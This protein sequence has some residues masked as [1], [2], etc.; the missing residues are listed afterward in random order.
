M[1]KIT[2]NL[3]IWGGA[4]LLPLLTRTFTLFLLFCLLLCSK[5][6]A[7]FLLL[8]DME[9]HG[10]CSGRWTFYAGNTTTGKVEFNIPNPAVTGLNTS[11]HVARFT[12]DTTSFEWMSASCSLPDSFDLSTNSVFKM[13]VRSNVIEDVMFKLQPGTNYSKAVFLTYRIKNINTWEEAVFDFKSVK[14]RTDFNTIVVQFIDGRK[15]NGILHFDL[16]QS[17]DRVNITL[18][19]TR[20][21][22]GQEQGAVIQATIHKNTF[23]S[24]LN[25]SNWTA[26]LPS[27]VTI[28]SLQ[29][30]N[31]T[32]V[33][34]VLAGNSLA[35]YSRFTLRL[36]IAGSELAGPAAAQYLALG[37][38]V[39][40]GNPNYTL[41]F[42][43][44]FNGTGL[45]DLTKWTVD[46]RPKG[47]IN[48]EQQ[49]YTDTSYDN[50]RVRNGSLVIT[51]KKDYPNYNTTEPWSSARLITRNKVDFR[52][53]KVE[54]RARLPRARG[55]WPAIWL[56]PTTESYG[57]WPKSGEIDIMEHVG[58]NF[59]TVLSTVH[60]Q[61]NNWTNGGH[62]SASKLIPDVDTVF[63]VYALEWSEDS[64]RFTYD[65]VKVY[66]YV[67]PKTDWKDWPFDQKF[68]IILNVAIG[69]GMGGAI[70]EANWPDSMLVDYVRVYQKGLGTPV[71]DSIVVSPANRAIVAGRKYQYT[72]KIFDQNDFPMSL[73]PVWSI[74]GSGNTITAGG[75]ACI[76]SPGIVTATVSYNG[77]TLS[78]T[79]NVTT[80][81][82]NFKPVPARIE[83]E[84]FDYSNTTRTE[85]VLDT[86]G[87]LNVSFIGATSFMEYDIEAPW[88]GS[89]RLQ[90][91]VA[92]NT[93]STVKVMMGDTLLTTMTLPASG[94]WQNWVTVTSAP[95]QMP[96]GKKTLLIQAATS[97][98]NFNWLKVVRA[99]D[100][101][102]S[103]I[104]VS[105]DSTSVFVGGKK[106][107]KAAAYGSDSSRFDIPFTWSVPAAGGV[108][109]YKGVFTASYTP[110]GYLV[111]ASYNS[112]SGYGKVKVLAAPQLA[113]IKV[114]PDSLTVPFGASQQYTTKGFDQ[115]GSA[116]AFT[117]PAWSV[118]GTGNSVTQAG[119]LTAGMEPGTFTITAVKDS[120]SGSAIF[121]TGY[122]CTFNKRYEA[123]ISTSRSPQPTLE[124]TTD[125]SGGQNF[126][127][128]GY[129]HWFGYSVLAIP[130]RGKYNVSF[131][132]LT[133][134][135]AKVK[136][137][138]SGITYGIISL[139]NTN[140][141]WATI[142]DTMTLPAISYANVIV[143]QGTFK[144][145]WFAINNCAVAPAPDTTASSL[146]MK[147][148]ISGDS[149]AP[150]AFRVYPNPVRDMITIE[151][152]RHH[153][154]TMKLL[155]MNGRLLRQWNVPAGNARFSKS[156]GNLP[157]GNY[158]LHLEG[159]SAPASIKIVKL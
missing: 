17:P 108:M 109:D 63:H 96:G 22:M 14:N 49:V 64:L 16:V 115:Y 112:M 52:Y 55:S 13:L 19:D 35:N 59:G 43:D 79:A 157:G 130:V 38:V 148:A 129:N 54:V 126:T 57:A 25:K 73:T 47:W 10:P 134:A 40:E 26:Q 156:L 3:P 56:M 50:A 20:I 147:S 124:P 121:T 116:F 8:D 7:Q 110:G 132:V 144:F 145:N 88:T 103:R 44:H 125:T 113:S 33:N 119:A 92:V 21:V 70:T 137:A 120:I 140:G 117:G 80:R 146:T 51:G 94:G 37:N 135:P 87:V 83:A 66:T 86:S 41:I 90:L 6:Q 91:R 53:G 136:L 29:R 114:V 74:T 101:S 75:L 23:D 153:Y 141:Q 65:G 11:S 1:K 106:P 71:P 32:T 123:E 45:P 24:V 99:T 155:D 77:D 82:A 142:T 105:P 143:Y 9:G 89:Y 150:L 127:G 28:D 97:G 48:G 12:K 122:G 72:A 118:S 102:L 42:E 2:I 131:R 149:E 67:N 27:G 31:D 30:V 69:G 60:T 95:F 62:L 104:V 138:N 46:P 81:V 151:Q 76:H 39:F 5:G 158:M 36:T 107:F 58:N 159:T 98:W 78:A 111:K 93:A 4:T 128:L 15:A 85:P 34:V 84:A 18:A 154:H 100:V 68:H 61:N 152:G 139:P 133:T